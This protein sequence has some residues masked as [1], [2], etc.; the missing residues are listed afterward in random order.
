MAGPR[1]LVVQHQ[2]DC[3]AG[4]LG[5]WLIE[6][7]CALEVVRPGAGDA[8]PEPGAYDGLV[9]LGGSMDADDPTVP[10][11]LPVRDL[12][13]RAAD[14]ELPTLGVCLG[15]Q[16]CALALGGEVARSPHGQYVGIYELGLSDR[17]PRHGPLP[18]RDDGPAPRRAV[19]WNDDV[20]TRLPDGAHAL[21]RDS[22]G[23]VQAAAFAPTVWGVQWHPEIA[24]GVPPS[25]AEEDVRRQTERGIDQA[26]V[27]REV[28]D[29]R[30]ELVAA[31]RELAVRFAA[32]A[33]A[34]A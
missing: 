32:L 24:G 34:S 31:E 11:L 2:E 29:A 26:R 30:A 7:G 23:E 8:L 28:D 15:H 16:L 13:R 4:L 9:V 14:R 21:A 17:G 6:A 22:R 12:V 33:E 10:W 19:F 5:E 3:P 27:L 18:A 1:V 25:W 20:V